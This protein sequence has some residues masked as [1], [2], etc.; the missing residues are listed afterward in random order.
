MRILDR[1]L[2]GTVL[3]YS[4]MVL[5]V[6]LTLGGLFVFIGQQDDI[7]IGDYGAADAL[8]FSLLS[9]PQQAYELMPI[10]VLIGALLGLGAL[11]RGSELVVVRA[12]GVSVMRTARAVAIGGLVI[13][14][15]TVA[16]GEFMAPPLQ[17]FAR[18]QK[19]FSKFSDVS[20]AGSGSAWIKD[21]ETMISVQEQTGNELFGGVFV[22]RFDGPQRL[23][24]VGQA[25]H[26]T[27]EQGSREW[28]LEGYRETRLNGA[29]V[30]GGAAPQATLTT[31]IDPGFL[32]LAVSEPRQLP[33]LGLFRLIR[34][35]RANGLETG[36]YEFA[37]WSRIARTCAIIVV[38]LLAV[39]FAFGPLRT[40]GAGARMVIGVLIGVAFFLVQRTL[41]SGAI[42]FELDPKVL[43]WIP[44]AMLA[45][46]TTILIARTR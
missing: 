34:H 18:Q 33:S 6:L 12:A 35:L 16:I 29:R 19:S 7:G 43:A 40:S 17:K 13:L 37:F 11:A 31:R 42:V 28:R 44:T 26:A 46:V 3:L 38:A 10:A 25:R 36:T 21:G 2:I 30:E 23:V 41:E 8:L 24:S 5:G 27:V 15:F 9:L 4:A 45:V 39:P 20:F 32:G 14:I 1:Y 22:F